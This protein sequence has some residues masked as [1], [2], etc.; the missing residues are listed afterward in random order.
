MINMDR[1]LKI[2]LIICIV[3]LVAG[4]CTYLFLRPYLQSNV[5]SKHMVSTRIQPLVQWLSAHTTWHQTGTQGGWA[6]FD[7]VYF[8]AVPERIE[9]VKQ[10]AAR[11]GIMEN[12]WI[13]QAIHKST[14]KANELQALNIVDPEYLAKLTPKQYGAIGCQLSHLAVILDCY[15]DPTAKTCLIF[16]DDIYKPS[17]EVTAQVIAFRKQIENLKVDWDILFLD[18]CSEARKGKTQGDI[19][20][21]TGS[22]CAHA[23]VIKKDVAPLLLNAT[24]PMKEQIDGVYCSLMQ[25]QA[26]VA[27]GPDKA[28][29][30]AQNRYG[31]DSCI[32][33]GFVENVQLVTRY[34]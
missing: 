30:F 34:R 10:V 29:F 31:Y 19:R 20:W 8:I 16:E 15:K 22:Y 27:I 28:R 17:K 9:N 24:T 1:N 25:K 13:L 21:L 2:C 4:Y 7:K 12:A 32:D 3:V 11:L 26:I 14:L 18:Y 33:P 5:Q 6:G 23:Y